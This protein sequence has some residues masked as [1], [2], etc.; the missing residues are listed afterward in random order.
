[1]PLDYSCQ[2]TKELGCFRDGFR[3]RILPT[4]LMALGG[5][6][7]EIC[8]ALAAEANLTA[9]DDFCGVEDGNQC[10]A[11]KLAA[12]NLTQA[13]ASECMAMP[14]GGNNS[15]ACGGPFLVSVFQAKCS[16]QQRPPVMM[17]VRDSGGAV[18]ATADV[19]SRLVSAAYNML[20][21]V[22]ATDRVRVWL[23]PSF[24]DVTGASVPPADEQQP[25]HAPAP[26]VDA[27]LTRGGHS[28]GLAAKASGSSRWLV[29]YAS[30]LPAQP[31]GVAAR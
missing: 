3:T 5:M 8:A 16:K 26:L 11:G 30:V 6:T 9:A 4:A 12:I 31:G 29:E 22:V 2:V 15:Q 1:M 25:P 13:N 7:H 23:N 27:K 19:T 21:I 24:K 14:C 10:W 20:R 28:R 18:L 17:T